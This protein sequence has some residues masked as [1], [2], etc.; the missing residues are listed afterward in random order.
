MNNNKSDYAPKSATLLREL[1][2]EH[3]IE[4]TGGV[5]P[6]QV[7]QLD[8]GSVNVLAVIHGTN[9]RGGVFR[10]VVEEAGHRYDEWSLAWGTP[11]PQ[12]LERYDAVIVFGGSMHADQEEHHPWLIEE[13]TFIQGLLERDVP[14]LGV[15]LGIQL[16]AKAEGSAVYPLAGGPEIGWVPVELTEAAADDPV[17]GSLPPALR[18]VRLALLHLRRP[19]AGRR[20]GHRPALQPGVPPRRARVGHPVPRR[21]DARD[22]PHVAR[23]QGRVPARPRPRRALGRDAGADRRVERPRAQALRRVRGQ[24]PS[25]RPSPPE[26]RFEAVRVARPTDRLDE[27][28]RFYRDGLGLPELGR[29]EGHARLRRRLHRPPRRGAPPGVHHRTWTGARV[30][31]R[32]GTTSSSST[33]RTQPRSP[34]SRRDWPRWATPRSNRRTRTGRRTDAVTIEDP[35]GWRVVLVPPHRLRPMNVGILTG[36]GDCPGLNAVIRAVAQ[37]VVRPRARGDR[38]PGRL[39][40]ARRERA[41]AAHAAGHQRAPPPRRD[42]P[43]HLADEPVQAGGRRRARA[44]ELRQRGDRRARRDRRRGHARRRGAGSTRSTEFPVVGVPKTIDNDLSATD[45][46]FGFDTAVSIATEAIDRLHTTAESHNRVMVVE[47]MGRHTG[48]IAVMSGIAGG[49]DVILIPEQPI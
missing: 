11:S 3:G 10:D 16:F 41:D 9:A 20:D 38:H 5:E 1:L 46:T 30:P 35:D 31:R 42:D 6:P 14:L 2:D 18:R 49:A 37:A 4:A 23:R 12:P 32:R 21:G 40:R 47:V 8:L 17:F 29:F 27:V 33:S 26:V 48:W 25:A 19:R 15:C 28:V 22:C 44:R 13:N 45:Y 43:R 36:G 39:A 7:G 34:R 24:W